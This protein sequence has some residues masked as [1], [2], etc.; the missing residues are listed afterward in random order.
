MQDVWLPS[1]AAKCRKEEAVRCASG[2]LAELALATATGHRAP[3]PRNNVPLLNQAVLR[4][5]L[6][7]LPPRR[8]ETHARPTPSLLRTTMGARFG[9]FFIYFFT[10][11]TFFFFK[12]A[13]NFY[14]FKEASEKCKC[15]FCTLF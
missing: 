5:A 14:G 6:A 15:Q 3:S 11:F 12:K 13:P 2:R 7:L 10:Y 1:N 9:I 8:G 4:R